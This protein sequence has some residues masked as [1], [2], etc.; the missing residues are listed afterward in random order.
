M[1][2][3]EIND[4]TLLTGGQNERENDMRRTKGAMRMEKGRAREEEWK[5]VDWKKRGERER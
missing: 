1:M 2:G 3:I 4:V 5:R